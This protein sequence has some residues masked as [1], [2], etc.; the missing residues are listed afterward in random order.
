MQAEDGCCSPNHVPELLSAT[1]LAVYRKS[2]S[3]KRKHN[4]AELSMAV[5]ESPINGVSCCVN[6]DCI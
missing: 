5:I 1:E 4:I 2:M 3:L 6:S